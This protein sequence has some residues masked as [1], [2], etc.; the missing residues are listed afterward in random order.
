MTHHE[1]PIEHVERAGAGPGLLRHLVGASAAIIRHLGDVVARTDIGLG[2]D[3]AAIR[4]LAHPDDVG[5]LDPFIGI[6]IDG[7][8]PFMDLRRIDPRQQGEVARHH[9]PLDMMRI[10]VIAGLSH[11]LRHAVHPRGRTPIDRR[12]VAVMP[13][14]VARGIVRPFQEIDAAHVFAPADDLADESFRRIQADLARG[15]GVG[16]GLAHLHRG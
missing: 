11:R 4:E 9:Q 7:Q 16:G 13:Q 6:D 3:H 1:I 12:Q 5:C 8:I 2:P 14:H 15:M 10:G